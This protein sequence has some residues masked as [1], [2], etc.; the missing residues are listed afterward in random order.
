MEAV[1]S[2]LPSSTTR[3][4][5]K[6]CR[7]TRRTVSSIRRSSLKA[8]IPT[9][10]R[11]RPSG[12]GSISLLGSLAGGRGRILAH[13]AP[14]VDGRPAAAYCRVPSMSGQDPSSARRAL[15]GLLLPCIVLALLKLWLVH[16]REVLASD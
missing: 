9:I 4:D 5:A 6:P 12:R 10:T 13:A 14:R 8:G 16:D 3:T 11:S 15:G 2:V 1:A 7:R